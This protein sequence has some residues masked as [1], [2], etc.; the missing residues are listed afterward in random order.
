MVGDAFGA[1]EW[2]VGTRAR[3][4]RRRSNIAVGPL[5]SEV[6]AVDDAIEG[7]EVNSF[8]LDTLDDL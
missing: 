2:G 5:Q 4:N 3:R 6:V 1:S 7:V 8:H